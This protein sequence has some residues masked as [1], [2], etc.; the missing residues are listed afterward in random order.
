MPPRRRRPSASLALLAAAAAVVLGACGSSAER[1]A[2]RAERR[3]IRDAAE[4]AAALATGASAVADSGEGDRTDDSAGRAGRARRARR[5]TGPNVRV[6]L[7]NN[8]KGDVVRGN[9]PPLGSGDVRV[10]SV[11]GMLTLAVI[12]D[13]VRMRAGDSVAVVARR[14]MVKQADTT[15]GFGGFVARTVTG[16]VG[17]ALDAASRF[18]V[19][20]PVAEVR[21]LRYEEGQIR[22]R[23]GDE[24]RRASKHK[25]DGGTSARFARADAER[26]IAAV[27]ARQRA[28]GV[29][30]A[31]G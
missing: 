1:D 14:E 16:A 2:R 3:A 18:A 17:G 8:S 19:R 13:T 6:A 11:D 29:A 31:G 9:D 27:R 5:D 20:V 15:A 23:T 4:R 24:G 10:T 26:F 22:F 30:D 28:L 25:H 21:D 12:G 7:G